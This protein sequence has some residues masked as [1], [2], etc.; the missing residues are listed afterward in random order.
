MTESLAA[1]PGHL[2]SH[3]SAI[4]ATLQQVAGAFGTAVFVT[5]ASLGTTQASGAPDAAGLH[6]AFIVAGVLGV[7][8]FVMALFVRRPKAAP[9][10]VTEGG[11]A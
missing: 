11:A 3:G 9:Q 6:T 1:L 10:A 5:V 8:V 4:M 2:Y 7:L